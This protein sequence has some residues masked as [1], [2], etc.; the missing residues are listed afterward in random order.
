MELESN[1]FACNSK[2]GIY[3][4][5]EEMKGNLTLEEGVFPPDLS[6]MSI[7]DRPSSPTQRSGESSEVDTKRVAQTLGAVSSMYHSP[8]ESKDHHTLPPAIPIASNG[9][10][11]RDSYHSHC[12][13]S[14]SLTAALIVPH[15]LRD[16][17]TTSAASSLSAATNTVNISAKSFDAFKC[18]R[19]KEAVD[20]DCGHYMEEN[21]FDVSEVDGIVCLQHRGSMST[22]RDRTGTFSSSGSDKSSHLSLSSIDEKFREISS[23]TLR[24][25]P[26]SPSSFFSSKVEDI[27]KQIVA[28][29]ETYETKEDCPRHQLKGE[30]E[31]RPQSS[32]KD[33][34][35][36]R[37]ARDAT[38]NLRRRIVKIDCKRPQLQRSVTT[39]AYGLGFKDDTSTSPNTVPVDVDEKRKTA[40]DFTD[41]PE[42]KA[43]KRSFQPCP[44][45]LRRIV[46][47]DQ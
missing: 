24:A 28:L 27:E 1:C 3:E 7:L 4:T 34:L 21:F 2:K 11:S 44:L 19:A 45:G 42:P 10:L 25:S 5:N 47:A 9:E 38:A 17:G 41:V 37:Q 30:V 22:S 35:I 14:S 15:T 43:P 13:P 23:G 33:D 31:P 40:M 18:L 12:R 8:I 39:R 32:A 16:E 20:L 36:L 26:R 29:I 46:S 6:S